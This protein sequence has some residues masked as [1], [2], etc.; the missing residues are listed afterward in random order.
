M[1]EVEIEQFIPIAKNPAKFDD[2]TQYKLEYKP[3][4][5]EPSQSVEPLAFRPIP[6]KFSGQTTHKS[7][8]VPHE[9]SPEKEVFVAAPKVL[10]AFT[11]STTYF[12]EFKGYEIPVGDISDQ[13]VSQRS[14]IKSQKKP[15][16]EGKTTYA[17]EYVEKEVPD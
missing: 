17:T 16:F 12:E 14:P 13:K 4:V 6:Q 11:G 7:D 9:I 15:K 1:A 2:L 10:P 3:H 5:I 8:F